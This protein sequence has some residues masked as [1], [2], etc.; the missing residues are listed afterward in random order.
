MTLDTTQHTS[1]VQ[2]VNLQEREVTKGVFCCVVYLVLCG[3]SVCGRVGE[4]VYLVLCGCSV[5]RRV[6]EVARSVHGQSVVLCALAVRKLRG[7]WLG[8]EGCDVFTC[9]FFKFFRIQG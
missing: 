4:V 2:R 1:K 9:L 5:C 8:G 3:C 6:G 7:E